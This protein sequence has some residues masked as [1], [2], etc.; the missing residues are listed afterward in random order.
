M[1][2]GEETL[3]DGRM[4]VGVI[5]LGLLTC[6][7]AEGLP[8]PWSFCLCRGRK[9]TPLLR[10]GD[11]DREEEGEEEGAVIQQKGQRTSGDPATPS[12]YHTGLI[13]CLI[14]LLHT[15]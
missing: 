15:D 14:L 1:G 8:Q 3:G 11:G 13:N 2:G 6:R 7:R 5:K 10:C 4:G 9:L 12:F